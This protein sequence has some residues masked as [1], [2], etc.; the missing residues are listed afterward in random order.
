MICTR[1]IGNFEVSKEIDKPGSEGEE[2]FGDSPTLLILLKNMPGKFQSIDCFVCLLVFVCEKINIF[3]FLLQV[4]LCSSLLT[5][6]WSVKAIF[7]ENKQ[8]GV[9]NVTRPEVLWPNSLCTGFFIVS[10]GF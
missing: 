9:R 10:S 5:S 2:T 8:I 7:S 4:S 3:L 6:K 1:S